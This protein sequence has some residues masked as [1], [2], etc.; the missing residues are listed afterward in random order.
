[1]IF[2]EIYG[3]YFRTMEKL[4]EK[5]INGTLDDSAFYQLISDN[6]F[7]ESVLFIDNEV[8]GEK[9]QI[10]DKNYRTPFQFTPKTPLA[11]M[12][13][14]WLKTISQDAKF[15]LF[16][17]E[18]PDWLGEIEPLFNLSDI[19]YPDKLC[20]GDDFESENY[21][22]IFKTI[23]RA[24]KENL[25]LNIQ[26]TSGKGYFHNAEF[27]PRK[28]EYS[29]KEDKFRLY[30]GNVF[31][32]N[33]IN[34][35]RISKCDIAGGFDKASLLPLKMNTAEVEFEITDER[36]CLERALIHFSSQEKQTT[37]IGEQKYLVKMRY[38]TDDETEIVIR[39]LQFGQF[40]KVVSPPN[41]VNQM[42]N[43]IFN[44]KGCE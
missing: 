26:Y 44:Q 37:K 6:A 38:N 15:L 11:D 35:G 16:V 10:V 41:M 40:V 21:R 22:Q 29:A 25:K 4:I 24:F 34:I 14:R 36:N 33:I 3:L 5:A 8:K 43:R 13:K 30:T 20:D 17:D 9:W 31:K 39:L 42:K 7:S 18:I 19:I 27:I 32:N 28:L 2:S 23:R 12:E 1:M